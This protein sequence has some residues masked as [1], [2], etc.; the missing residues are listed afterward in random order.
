MMSKEVRDFSIIGEGKEFF[1]YR[2]KKETG[3]VY[4]K[5]KENKAWANDDV[6]VVEYHE[7][8]Y[9]ILN[10]L[11]FTSLIPSVFEKID[12]DGFGEVIRVEDL[13]EDGKNTVLALE[14]LDDVDSPK[15]SNLFRR[16]RINS[17]QV[18]MKKEELRRLLLGKGSQGLMDQLGMKNIVMGADSF[19][20]IIKADGEVDVSLD[21]FGTVLVKNDWDYKRVNQQNFSCVMTLLSKLST[22]V[23]ISENKI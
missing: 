10:F 23:W 4:K 3:V 15:I 1:V 13:S 18:Y 22:L 7:K 20:I 2:P 8:I 11:G 16:I 5:P 6:S 9:G 14:D 17:Q 19:H 21:D 12:I